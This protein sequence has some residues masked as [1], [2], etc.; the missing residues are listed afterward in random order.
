MLPMLPPDYTQ[1]IV[2]SGGVNPEREDWNQ[3]SSLFSSFSSSR[4]WTHREIDPCRTNGLLSKLLLLRPSSEL[5]LSP[6]IPNGPTT[7]IFLKD[8]QWVRIDPVI[9]RKLLSY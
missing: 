1:T 8:V 5:L 2:F 7:T 3:V 6:M 9:E 4:A